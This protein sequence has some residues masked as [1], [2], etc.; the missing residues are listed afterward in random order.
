[1]KAKL[2]ALLLVEEYKHR[3]LEGNYMH[4]LAF[5][6]SQISDKKRGNHEQGYWLAVKQIEADE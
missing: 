1:M 3:V 2:A 6:K 4:Y 5:L